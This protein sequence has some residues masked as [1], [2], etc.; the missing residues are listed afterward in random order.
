MSESRMKECR[1]VLSESMLVALLH[2]EFA[3][4]W[5]YCVIE[6]EPG[7]VEPHPLHDEEGVKKYCIDKAKRLRKELRRFVTRV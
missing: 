4:G 3:C 1:Y 2:K 5:T 6:D 7:P